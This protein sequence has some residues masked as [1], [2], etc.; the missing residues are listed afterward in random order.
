MQSWGYGVKWSKIEPI[1][2]KIII[3]VCTGPSLEGFDFNL[4]KNSD[5]YVIAV[6]DAAKYVPF[7]HA[8]FTLDP[9]GLTTTQIPRNCKSKL[10][11]AIPEDYGTEDA[12]I[13]NHK[14][15]PNRNIHYLHRIPHSTNEYHRI[16]EYHIVGLNEDPSCIM[17]GNSGYG[18]L[19]LAYHMYPEKVI[20]LGLDASSGYF[21]DKN[22]A[23]RS[24]L[25][26][27]DMFASAIPQL[28]KRGIE[29]INASEDSN[30]KCF[31]RCNPTDYFNPPD[32]HKSKIVR[33]LAST[34][35][36]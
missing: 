26:L 35:T 19:N 1:E 9:W 31:P 34:K 11:A 8:W 27:N 22:K 3:I 21:F 33:P 29:V 24:L 5:Y 15:I 18:A 4:I 23:T 16:R 13:T 2:Q 32:D 36:R 14:V 6:N 28:T 17:T 10:Y 20:Y 7:A 12:K 25:H 30:V